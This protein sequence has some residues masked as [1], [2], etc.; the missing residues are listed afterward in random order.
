MIE[1]LALDCGADVLGFGDVSEALPPGFA[2]LP[3]GI[4]VGMA[5]AQSP[6][7]AA[8]YDHRDVEIQSALDE[9]LREIA[10]FLRLRGYR[11]FCCPAECDPM[12]SPFTARMAHRFSHK[13]AATCAGLGWVGRNGLLIHPELGPCVSWATVVTNAP[14]PLGDPWT[15]GECRG[16]MACAEACPAGAISGKGWRRSQGMHRLV[17]ADRCRDSLDTVERETGARVC[18][19][20]ALACAAVYRGKGA[21]DRKQ[22]ALNWSNL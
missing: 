19:R 8:R 16:C 5:N 22:L 18:G 12:E 7:G 6:G 11:Y 9:A 20:C 3:V 21:A 13:A 15:E 17:D 2:H 4:S 14:L 1:E 10:A